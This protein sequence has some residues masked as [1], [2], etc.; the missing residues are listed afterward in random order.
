M[1]ADKVVIEI[2]NQNEYAPIKVI[3]DGKEIKNVVKIDFHAE[4]ASGRT[5]RS[6]VIERYGEWSK[7]AQGIPDI[8]REKIKIEI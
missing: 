8:E 1:K 5:T 4:Y 6:L 3:V 2:E 7:N